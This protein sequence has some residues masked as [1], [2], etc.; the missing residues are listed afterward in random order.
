MKES[1]ELSE[2]IEVKALNSLQTYLE[3]EFLL[4]NATDAE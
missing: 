2:S 4:L 1:V 3:Y